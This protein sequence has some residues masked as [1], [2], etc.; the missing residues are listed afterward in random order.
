M[1][2]D[3]PHYGAVHHDRP[4]SI[5][6]CQ[7]SLDHP[8]YGSTLS[9]SGET[10]DS[11]SIQANH[12]SAPLSNKSGDD[13]TAN[14][15]NY[16]AAPDVR[17]KVHNSATFTHLQSGGPSVETGSQRY[18][19]TAHNKNGH[20]HQCFGE[21][22]AEYFLK[23]D[24]H[25]TPLCRLAHKVNGNGLALAD[26]LGERSQISYPEND[27][28]TVLFPNQDDVSAGASGTRLQCWAYE[29]SDA[30]ITFTE[31]LEKR[32]WGHWSLSVC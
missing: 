27:Q 18:D 28:D 7:T 26:N 30:N 6:E 31:R 17:G 21:A 9:L 3:M 13:S 8:N 29:F 15:S 32:K 16:F 20:G 2:L 24:G 5:I 10:V 12:G 23:A 19:F 1:L 22:T 25:E 4:K 11:R 14:D